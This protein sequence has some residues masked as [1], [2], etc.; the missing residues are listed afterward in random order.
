[1]IRFKDLYKLVFFLTSVFFW[2]IFLILLVCPN[3]QFL[4][5]ILFFVNVLFF[6]GGLS[7]HLIAYQLAI[8]FQQFGTLSIGILLSNLDTRQ[9][10]TSPRTFFGQFLHMSTSGDSRSIQVLLAKLGAFRK[11]I[12]S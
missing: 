4:F 5:N 7:L 1:M 10:M 6:L 12:F 11:S 3:V 9:L 8:S 2:P